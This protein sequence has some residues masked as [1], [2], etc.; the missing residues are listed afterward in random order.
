VNWLLLSARLLLALVFVVAG[1]AKLCD[2]SGSRRAVADFG[3]PSWLAKPLG[4]ALPAVELAVG[5]ALIPIATARFGALVALVLLTSFALAI[6][7]A[8]YRGEKPDCNCFGQLHS[9]SVGWSTLARDLALMAVAGFLVAAGWSNAGSSAT[10]WIARLNTT[11][12]VGLL[13]GL[14][15]VTALA[16]LGW[17]SLQLLRQNGRLVARVDALEARVGVAMPGAAL[18]GGAPDGRV[19][20]TVRGGGA[21]AGLPAGSPAPEFSLEDAT[22][23]RQT[24]ASLLELERPLML[25]FSDPGCGPC[26]ALLPELA[27]WQRDD[28]SGLTIALI[29]QG[30]RAHAQGR[31]EEHGLLNV[32]CDRDRDVFCRYRAQGTPSAVVVDR[33]GR[34]ATPLAEGPQAIRG[35]LTTAIM[36]SLARAEAPGGNGPVG[37]RARPLPAGAAA[38]DFAL[39]DLDG[40]TWSL[41]DLRG[42]ATLLVFW[43]PR[44]GFCRQMLDDLR[45]V[46]AQHSDGDPR[47]V[48][49]ATGG[50]E[51]NRAQDLRSLVLL[52]RGLAAGA[53]FGATATPSG[54][55]IDGAGRVASPLAMGAP[56][57]LALLREHVAAPVTSSVGH[58]GAR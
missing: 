20:S 23:G 28:A 3:A 2:L 26:T 53:A 33:Q 49:I 31:A 37:A 17:F 12:A 44:C 40:A 41:A 6:G 36:E 35:L 15:T 30:D 48:V 29:S 11:Q 32:L 46:E 39:P 42:R 5:F 25:V 34:V 45:A 16:F 19:A 14:L 9:A 21:P 22:G 56:G 7:R 58:G 18:A 24:L 51:E 57:L 52:D 8:L 54:V 50:A 38:P 4:T 27:E 55:L 13:V 43:N 10:S 47:L 1:V